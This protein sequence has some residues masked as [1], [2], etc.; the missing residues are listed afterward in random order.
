MSKGNQNKQKFHECLTFIT[1]TKIS[2]RLWSAHDRHNE[3]A[4]EFT[5]TNNL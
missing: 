3:M 4:T 1:H 5:K 2:R